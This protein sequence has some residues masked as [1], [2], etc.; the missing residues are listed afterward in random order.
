MRLA[1]VYQRCQPLTAHRDLREER[2]QQRRCIAVIDAPVVIEVC[3]VL[4]GGR[5]LHLCLCMLADILKIAICSAAICFASYREISAAFPIG[6]I[7]NSTRPATA[8]YTAHKS[9]R[10]SHCTGIVHICHSAL[11]ITS[12]TANRRDSAHG[13][14]I[15]HIC[16]SALR[17]TSYTAHIMAGSS[18]ITGI[19]HICHSTLA[20]LTSYTAHKSNSA[21]S[22]GIVHIAQSDIITTDL[23]N[24]TADLLGCYAGSLHR[25][26]IVHTIHI[27]RRITSY[28][29]HRIAGT[30]HITGI[31]HIYHSARRI[32]SY[33]A[34]LF[35]CFTGSLHRAL[36]VHICHST[37]G[38]TSYT[39]HR[40]AG[41]SHITGI[42][43][44]CHSARRAS[45]TAHKLATA[46]G[47]GIVHI[48]H[49][50]LA[51]PTSYTA[52]KSDSA[53]GTSI[54]HICH[55]AL[56]PTSYTANRLAG[57][58][59]ITGIIHICHSA[60]RPTSYTANTNET[61]HGT[62]IV[63][64]C[65]S[66]RR[67]SYTAHKSAGTSHITG[68]VHICH[69]ALR[70]TSYTTDMLPAGNGTMDKPQ[71]ADGPHRIAN[72]PHIVLPRPVNHQAVDCMAETVKRTLELSARIS[73]RAEAMIDFLGCIV[74]PCRRLFCVDI[75][76]EDIVPAQI[77]IHI[78]QIIDVVHAHVVIAVLRRRAVKR[79]DGPFQRSRR[80][81]LIVGCRGI[82]LHRF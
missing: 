18:H 46:H 2:L 49:S 57:T 80:F 4:I 38:L 14:G 27:A 71:V 26:L 39:A 33:T 65:H 48:C 81:R 63:H 68:I 35:G 3:P 67:A 19:V 50:T 17:I 69:S 56:R 10:T 44:I 34:D 6:G 25:A 52:N 70:I 58:S 47:T 61:A 32:T 20:R 15:V 21:H 36:I 55:S 53:H 40:I 51:R 13:T 74:V 77:R 31:V 5:L 76:R 7:C 30:S 43:H 78:L 1:V 12:Y 73:Y 79:R 66:A 62:G 60:L 82:V 9:V 72:Q 22:T 45:Y 59:H 29:A 42:V 64:I 24:Y 23:A 41:T 54:V 8:S 11:R 37:L 75:A 28:T 16:H